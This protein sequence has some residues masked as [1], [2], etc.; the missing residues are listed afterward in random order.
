[1]FKSPTKLNGKYRVPMYPFL[2][3][4]PQYAQPAPL[5]ISPHQKVHW[6]QLINLID[7]L[8]LPYVNSL[9]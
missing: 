5:L 6:L 9:H 7:T 4:P 8:L 2:P 3:P 1:M